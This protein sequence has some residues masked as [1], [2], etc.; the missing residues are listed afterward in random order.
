V[1]Y[2]HIAD[3]GR[4]GTG[5]AGNRSLGNHSASD[6]D[7]TVTWRRCWKRDQVRVPAGTAAGQDAVASPERPGRGSWH[8]R[9]GTRQIDLRRAFHGPGMHPAP[10]G[11][12]HPRTVAERRRSPDFRSAHNAEYSRRQ[13]SSVGGRVN[14][15]PPVMSS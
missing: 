14:T 3:R 5:G 9:A 12:V 11:D 6:G 8:A 15:E 4:V 10:P 13:P 1:G 2:G 7:V